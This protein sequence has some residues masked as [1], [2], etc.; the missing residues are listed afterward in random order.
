MLVNVDDNRC[1][2]EQLRFCGFQRHSRAA[3]SDLH[4]STVALL[5]GCLPLHLQRGLVKNHWALL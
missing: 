5:L 3:I 2:Q 1:L 4:S